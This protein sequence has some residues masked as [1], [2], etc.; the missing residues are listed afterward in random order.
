MIERSFA[1][2]CPTIAYHLVGTKK[3]QQVLATPGVVEQFIDDPEVQRQIRDTFTGLYSLDL[4][5]FFL[6]MQCH[7]SKIE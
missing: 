1:I 6:Y 7:R 3:V 5:R 2:K 4:V